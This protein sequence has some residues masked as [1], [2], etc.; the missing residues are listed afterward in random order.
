MIRVLSLETRT[1]PMRLRM[2]FR[3][4][5]VTLTELPHLFVR[6][7]VEVGG[8]VAT[9]VA[10]DGLAPKWFTKDPHTTIAQD[11]AEM[12]AV[13]AAAC[14]FAEQA[15]PAATVFD[16]W[17]AIYAEQSVWASNHG[18]PPLLWG[19]GVSLVERAL[20]DAWCRATHTPFYQAVCANTLGIRLAAIH[21]D[22]GNREPD[23]FLPTAPRRSIIV[24]HTV[25]LS[26][27]IDDADI[28]PHER[29]DD[30]LPQSLAANIRAYGLTHFKIK[31]SGDGEK[32]L[33][34]L[35]ALAQVIE[36]LCPSF[37]FTLDGNEQYHDVAAFQAAW[38]AIKQE[39]RLQSFLRH[40]LFVEQPLHRDVAL[41]EATGQALRAWRDRPPL[42]IDESDGELDS[43]R[44][45]RA[46]GYAGASHKN[47]KG[48]FKGI[49]NACWLQQ[50]GG[51]LSGEDLC[52]IGPVA[53]LQDLAV[54]ATLGIPHVER[55]GH[56]YARG[57][58]MFPATLQTQV[59]AQHGDLYR[60]REDGF[61]TLAIGDGAIHLDS[62]IDAPFGYTVDLN[63]D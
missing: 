59:A 47:C 15:A 55:N 49:A 5:I 28:A 22:L 19:F 23:E 44:V 39:P 13:I 29:L 46:C 3:Y 33:A 60:R 42:I 45:A 16:L 57:L 37:A 7:Q 20:I 14:A 8:R 34:R 48:V 40:L 9:G 51:V 12:R 30:G 24:R 62:V 6:A 1:L 4:G 25:G 18:Y 52:N 21:S 27:P 2:P 58:S 17:Q 50:T 54:V 11:E 53:L 41:S 36:S 31:L 43:V 63:L 35:Y 61:V 32:D 10:A 26:D 56:H 38:S